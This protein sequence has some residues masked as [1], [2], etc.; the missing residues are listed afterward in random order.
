M[1]PTSARNEAHGPPGRGPP[2]SACTPPSVR[3]PPSA[4]DEERCHLRSVTQSAATPSARTPSSARDVKVAP[5]GLGRDLQPTKRRC[6][7]RLSDP[8]G[9]TTLSVHDVQSAQPA[10]TRPSASPNIRHAQ[11][12]KRACFFS[13]NNLIS[14]IISFVS[15]SMDFYSKP[16]QLIYFGYFFLPWT[17]YLG[18]PYDF[19][20]TGDAPSSTIRNY[21]RR[22]EKYL[23][24]LVL[25]PLCLSRGNSWLLTLRHHFGW[26][27]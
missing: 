22:D 4:H 13:L 2:P 18:S 12:A 19:W 1:V 15:T 11:A 24:R 17:K 14:S 25:Q 9:P 6:H 27:L 20:R 16:K 21:L 7:P 10:P 23:R 3:A 26:I 5:L 8:F